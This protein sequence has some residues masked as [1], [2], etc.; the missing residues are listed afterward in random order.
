M[1][2]EEFKCPSSIAQECP[3]AKNLS[4]LYIN[5]TSG[6]TQLKEGHSYYAQV[7]GQI[8]KSNRKYCDF[9][10]YTNTGHFSQRILFDSDYW[11]KLL[12]NLEYFFK[13][14]LVKELLPKVIISILLN[15]VYTYLAFIVSEIDLILFS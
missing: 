9:F 1:G 4:Y 10:V 8:A 6:A 3:S 5:P 14:Y 12:L 15:N 11:Q 13:N 7:Q 2:V